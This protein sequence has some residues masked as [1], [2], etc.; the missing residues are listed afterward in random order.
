M[1]TRLDKCMVRNRV[2]DTAAAGPGQASAIPVDQHGVE[3]GVT[4]SAD[5]D[6]RSRD[7]ETRCPAPERL[8]RFAARGTEVLF[9]FSG[10]PLPRIPGGIA[11]FFASGFTQSARS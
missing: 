8:S 3:P 9:V 1:A 2:A 7:H 5:R 11:D 10:A 6:L 4:C